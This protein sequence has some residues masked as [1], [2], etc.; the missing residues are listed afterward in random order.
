MIAALLFTGCASIRSGRER[1]R[2]VHAGQPRGVA[3]IIEPTDAVS[4]SPGS[5]ELLDV[6][7][8]NALEHA[9]DAQVRRSTLQ[10]AA[11]SE[12]E[13]F[14]L[15]LP[16]AQKASQDVGAVLKEAAEAVGMEDDPAAHGALIREIAAY[17][18][19]MRRSFLAASL[20]GLIDGL[21]ARGASPIEDSGAAQR[22]SDLA[23]SPDLELAE[24]AR[25][26]A[27]FFVGP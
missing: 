9:H 8:Q 22:L 5:H 6:L 24:A 19:C 26:A 18:C 2:A 21:Q 27:A 7:A 15:L 25:K 20:R 14:K 13:Y 3:P 23:L 12:F 1:P 4:V 10:A 17:E 16:R 11:G